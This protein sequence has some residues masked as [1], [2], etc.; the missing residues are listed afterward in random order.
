M[1]YQADTGK[2][3]FDMITCLVAVIVAVIPVIT[4]PVEAEVQN[5][6]RECVTFARVDH[7]TMIT[8]LTGTM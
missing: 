3:R 8:Y 2:R 7:F 5:H 6:S 1:A 4:I